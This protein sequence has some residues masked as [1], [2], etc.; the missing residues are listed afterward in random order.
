[1]WVWKSDTQITRKSSTAMCY[2]INVIVNVILFMFCL[3]VLQAASRG[4]WGRAWS[5]WRSRL[6]DHV[7]LRRGICQVGYHCP[8]YHHRNLYGSAWKLTA[9]VFE[10]V[11]GLDKGLGACGVL[12]GARL[13]S[14][15]SIR[16]GQAHK[17]WWNKIC[18]NKWPIYNVLTR[19]I[20]EAREQVTQQKKNLRNKRQLWT[21]ES[22]SVMRGWLETNLLTS[23]S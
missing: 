19:A 7:S 22:D 15:H 8:T 2:I 14:G 10:W 18:W 1:M 6:C 23:L 13:R 9:Q 12:G 3:I 20:E 5:R 11:S 17:P 21:S 16:Q 4:S